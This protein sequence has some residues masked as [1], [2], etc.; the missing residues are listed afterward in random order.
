MHN[1]SSETLIHLKDRKETIGFQGH[2]SDV[3]YF[4]NGTTQGGILI[5]TLFNYVINDVLKM[6]FEDGIHLTA[7]ADELALHG[8]SR[9]EDSFLEKEDFR[10]S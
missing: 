3:H 5:A 1:G 4:Q 8:I 6:E 10:P 7:Y 2:S 9:H